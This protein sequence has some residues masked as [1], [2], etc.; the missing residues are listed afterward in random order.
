MR[1]EDLMEA[2]DE[3]IRRYWR[4]ELPK[5][6]ARPWALAIRSPHGPRSWLPLSHYASGMAACGGGIVRVSLLAAGTG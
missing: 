4:T 5:S 1:G 3:F 2:Q 6:G